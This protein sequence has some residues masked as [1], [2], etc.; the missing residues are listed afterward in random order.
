MSKIVKLGLDFENL[1]HYELDAKSITYLAIGDVARHFDFDTDQHALE[2]TDVIQSMSLHLKLSDI[3][4]IMTDA[5]QYNKQLN[6]AKRLVAFRD[7][8][9]ISL[10]DDKDHEKAFA[11]AWNDYDDEINYNAAA[12]ID[13]ERNELQFYFNT[14][15]AK[16][17]RTKNY[18]KMQDAA[19]RFRKM[20]EQHE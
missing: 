18:W 6:L 10:I 16:I 19:K 5:E 3:T 12:H 7:L 8:S 14:D 9:Y 11:L 20:R 15:F 2:A 4:K 13:E 17:T 1:E